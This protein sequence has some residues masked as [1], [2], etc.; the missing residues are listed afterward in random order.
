MKI[1]RISIS[2]WRN[3]ENVDIQVD[4]NKKLLCVVGEN[5]TGKSNIL[6]LIAASAHKFGLSP[7][8][9]IPR[10]NPFEEPHDF[11]LQFTFPEDFVSVFRDEP[12]GS[13]NDATWNGSLTLQSSN[14]STKITAGGEHDNADAENIARQINQ[15]LENLNDVHFLSLDGNR[16]YPKLNLQQ[17]Q[18]AQAYETNWSTKQFT[19]QR[20]FMNTATLYDEWLKYFLAK[21]NQAGTEF[22][23]VIRKSRQS[24]QVDPQ[25][26]DHFDSYK[27]SLS[28]I[29]PHLIFTGVCPKRKTLL[30]NSSGLELSFDQLS[31]GE[32]EI[33]FLLGQIDRFSLR[34]G[35]FVLDEPE[36][37]LNSDLIRL[38][39]AYLVDTFKSGQMW[40][41]THSL[42]AVE[43]AGQDATFIL[44]RDNATRKVQKIY[45]LD[46]QP[47]LST[48]SRAVGSPAFSISNY[49]FIYIEG[50]EK[51]GEREIFRKLVNSQ[52]KTKFIEAGSCHEVIRRVRVIEDLAREANIEIRI[53]GVV[54]RDFRTEEDILMLEE[55]HGIYVLCVHEI[56]NFFIHPDVLMYLSIQNG[57]EDFEP[58]E[59]ILKLSDE[60][61]GNWIFQH[62]NQ[63][64]IFPDTF[65]EWTSISKDLAKK[66]TWAEISSDQNAVIDTIFGSLN[67]P[68]KELKKLHIVFNKSV[69]KYEEIRNGNNLWKFCEGK[70]IM[71]QIAKK[72]GFT[73]PATLRSATFKVWESNTNLIPSELIYFRNHIEQQ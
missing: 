13:P 42:E 2:S 33:A 6:E 44:E 37:H 22:L 65:I 21:E 46:S 41:A 60:R 70:Q 72:I 20:S 32:K 55:N 57:I 24:G 68:S 29:F 59:T 56:E 27:E 71:H 63:S 30:F 40:I 8:T 50:D 62:A 45:R 64:K 9:D 10:G 16:G 66:V 48:L 14:A 25:F 12:S 5:G 18:I 19:K 49:L 31:G 52:R 7:G 35:L 4:E 51:I 34:D 26:E 3:F 36:L 38:W 1:T 15:K 39:V 58:D 17:H 23:T 69:S 67:L 47:V 61:A 11:T 28:T 53:K 54:D 43:A 73:E